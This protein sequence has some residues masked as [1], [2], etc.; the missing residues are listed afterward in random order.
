M[1]KKVYDLD[2]YM[3]KCYDETKIPNDIFN[4]TYRNLKTA[5]NNKKLYLGLVA[6][7]SFI[8]VT[9]GAFRFGYD[10]NLNINDPQ[11]NIENATNNNAIDNE[12]NNVQIG[13]KG[14]ES[15]SL[16]A[17][18]DITPEEGIHS[19][20]AFGEVE[21][22]L[23]I[24]LDKIL[25]GTCHL[26]DR[27][28]YSYPITRVKGTVLK[29]FRGNYNEKEVEFYIFGGKIPMTEYINLM[30]DKEKERYNI[31]SLSKEDIENTDA[32]V[33][34]MWVQNQAEA[35]EGKTYIVSLNYD[36]R[37]YKSLRILPQLEEYNF[38]FY[39][40]ENNTYQEYTGEWKEVDLD[41]HRFNGIYDYDLKKWVR[42]EME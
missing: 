12:I 41:N 22:V 35:I 23:A 38:K 20:M 6:S 13:N 3:K 37:R 8:F 17:S 2:L 39:N 21:Y 29:D 4:E 19:Y 16:R 33:E 15:V 25:E 27:D 14:D 26:K 18:I 1:N 5:K 28:T 36:E 40:M 42:I 31:S 11:I 7:L 30:D 34:L 32:N 10:K 9:I 24:K